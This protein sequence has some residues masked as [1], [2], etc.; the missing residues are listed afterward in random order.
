MF[1]NDLMALKA[2]PHLKAAGLGVPDDLSLVGFDN[3]ERI[4]ET[5]QPALTTVQ[6]P[7]DAIGAIA[8]ERLFAMLNGEFNE[9]SVAKVPC[10]IVHRESTC[11][12]GVRTASVTSAA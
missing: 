5:I 7:Y 3:D 12:I 4:C 9:S 1:G 8:A 6:L 10:E 11:A 2:V